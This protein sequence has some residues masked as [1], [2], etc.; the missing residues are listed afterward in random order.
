MN[1]AQDLGGAMGF[2]PIDPEPDEPVFH[3]DWEQRVLALTLAIG[4]FGQWSIDKGRF[5]RESLPPARYLSSSY[6]QIWFAALE[7]LL[8]EKNF[9][10][11]DEVAAG[12]ALTPAKTLKRPAVTAAEIESLLAAGTAYTRTPPGPAR[13]K[14]GDKVRTRN[15]HPTGHT[16]LARYLR[17]HVGEIA[18][19]H[20]AHVFPD[21]NAH[22]R[23]EDPQWL[24]SV[25]F[26]AR[27]LWGD[28]RNANDHVHADLWEPYLDVV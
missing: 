9:I 18:T 7:K 12:K 1:G 19:I 27:E 2:G 10:T 16:R 5:T 8:L 15:M 28:D 6:Y 23:G 14:V 24:Y 4:F 25:R 11:D 17:N 20:G 26:S 13:F 3:H 22:D 21:S